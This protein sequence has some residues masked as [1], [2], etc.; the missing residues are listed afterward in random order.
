MD[1]NGRRDRVLEQM[2]EHSALILF[3]GVELHDSLDAY[4]NFE[5]N[6]HFF[7]LTGLRRE[8]MILVMVKEGETPRTMLFLEEADPTAVRWTGKRVSKEEAK[9]ISGIEEIYYLPSFEG[10]V[11]R[12]LG[13]EIDTLYCDCSRNQWDDLPDYNTVKVQEIA[14]KYP[15]V[16]LKNI[17]PV[18]AKMRMQKDADEIKE[19]RAAI[20]VTDQALQ[21]VMNRLTPGRKEYQVQ[22]DF[23]YTVRFL[24]ADGVSFPTI[25]GSGANG[26]M[27]HYETNR[28]TCE[29]DSLVLLDLGA[30]VNGYCADI[31]RTYPVNGKYTPRQRQ[32]YNIVLRANRE[33]AK[34]AKPG[35]TLRDLQKLCSDILAQGCM[36]LGLIEK[37][38]E[39]G[40][41]YMH[42]VS[43]HLGIDVH[44]V[45]AGFN[46]PL[47][48]GA[49][50]TDEPGLY[51]DEWEIGIRIEDDL[52]ITETG[53]EVLSEQVI[54]DPDEI[55]AFMA[56]SR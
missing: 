15:G 14:G 34:A 20:D 22:A 33:V 28:D 36:E 3:S 40:K 17:V 41:Y 10:M 27:L 46:A 43:H 5:A 56:K 45:T 32:V 42:G 26:T 2:A 48:P 9:E 1:Y 49:V 53:C 37:P 39:I 4:A 11:N 8:R 30:K 51:I 29:D 13:G 23:E 16:Q 18:V 54:R 50:I 25:A 44:D 21:N 38:E 47:A 7:Y 12:L 35:M 55:E 52:L 31:T 19:I 6:R 24:G